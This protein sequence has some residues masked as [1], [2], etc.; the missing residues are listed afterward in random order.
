MKHLSAGATALVLLA[1]IA[2]SAAHCA[3]AMPFSEGFIQVPGGPVWYRTAG[4][5]TRIPLL[6]LHGGPGG[7]SCGF[8]RLEPLG[9]ERPVIRYDQLGTGRSGRPDDL[10]LWEVDR[11]IEAL[12]SV[13]EQ[14]GLEQVHLLGHSWGGALAAAYVLAKGSEGIVS[15]T[16]SSPLLS[17]SRWVAD[18]NLL[19]N[20]LPDDIQKVLA[21]HEEEGSTDSEEYREASEVFYERHVY[22]GPKPADLEACNGAPWN[23]VIYEHMWGPT[24]FYA[25]GNLIDFDV[26]SRLHE[27]DIP[28]LFIAG[29]YDEARP[30]TVAEF[31][32]RI[33]GA[34]LEVI[35][36]AAHATL[37]RKPEQYRFLLRGFL[38][39]A[40]AG[41]TPAVVQ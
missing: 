28:V 10:S 41:L 17:T 1:L 18:A 19:R 21:K 16:L 33:P 31:Q 5:G 11:F 8:S 9:D 30:E 3:E 26:T 22:A 29:Q 20:Q 35:V 37:S 7:T 12:H 23:P 25:T 15:L 24:E 6:T 34:R 38:N 32:R 4:S 27:I 39:E 14:L 36:D 40:E 2:S 13:R